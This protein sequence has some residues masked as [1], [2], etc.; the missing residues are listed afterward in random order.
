MHQESCGAVAGQVLAGWLNTQSFSLPCLLLLLPS[1]I[2]QFAVQVQTFEY[3]V[4][5]GQ[6][7]YLLRRSLDPVP[8]LAGL[9]I[10]TGILQLT[11]DALS[12]ILDESQCKL[13]KNA[14]KTQKIRAICSLDIVMQHVK[15]ACISK[16]LALCDK[17]D[18]KRVQ[19][20]AAQDTEEDDEEDEDVATRLLWTLD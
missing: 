10:S 1:A 14:T 5:L 13:R 18:E 8:L 3:S 6:E 7:G 2:C 9:I 12:R 11:S 19:K 17:L 4:H 15:K 16:V 20:T